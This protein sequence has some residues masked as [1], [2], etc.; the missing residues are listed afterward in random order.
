MVKSKKE[1]DPMDTIV[2]SL[3]KAA[4]S[5][6]DTTKQNGEVAVVANSSTESKRLPITFKSIL[7]QA[8]NGSS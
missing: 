1:I 5:N 4:M 6:T 7:K 3:L 2:S 8:K